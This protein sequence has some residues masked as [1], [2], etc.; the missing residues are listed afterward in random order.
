[1]Q[2]KKGTFIT[3]LGKNGANKGCR[4]AEGLA[5]A[6]EDTDAKTDEKKYV[7]MV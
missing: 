4:D 3:L 2:W 7:L 1:M 5:K 6:P